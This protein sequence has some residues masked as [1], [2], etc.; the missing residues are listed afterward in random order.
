MTRTKLR[1]IALFPVLALVAFATVN[2]SESV[3][4]GDPEG[5]DIRALGL[6]VTTTSAVLPAT[7]ST[8][9]PTTTVA[10]TTSLPPSTSTTTTIAVVTTTET[11][12]PATTAVVVT[13]APAT[14]AAAPTTTIA[15]VTTTE[16]PSVGIA[17]VEL[18]GST[19]AVG[20]RATGVVVSPTGIALPIL[21][22]EAGAWIV[23]TPCGKQATIGVGQ[24]ID[25]VDIVLDAG[26]GGREPGSV[27]D[28][29]LVEKE[30]NLAVT[31]LVADHLRADGYS[32]LLTRSSDVRIPLLSR[33]EIARSVRPKA[34]VS[35][36]HNGGS[37]CVLV[38]T[39]DRGLLP[40]ELVGSSAAQW[41]LVRR[42]LCGDGTVRL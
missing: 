32:V 37:G 33:A 23:R 42:D 34:F 1:Q 31:L 8:S 22:G 9:A 12:A 38:D 13:A 2:A 4:S 25:S 40:G 15:P 7:T 29:G 35:I 24:T 10:P 36:H 16:A 30:L 19:V 21:G 17:A 14:T 11:V 28:N 26:H 39:R 3:G 27:G 6:N 41:N 20:E 18:P 5:F